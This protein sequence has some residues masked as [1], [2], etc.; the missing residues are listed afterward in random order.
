MRSNHIAYVHKAERAWVNMIKS[1]LNVI[2]AIKLPWRLTS[3]VC[4]Q[5]DKGLPHCDAREQLRCLHGR[6]YKNKT[7]L[8]CRNTIPDLSS[9]PLLGITR[10]TE[11]PAAALMKF[12]SSESPPSGSSGSSGSGGPGTQ[13]IAADSGHT[14]SRMSV[15]RK[16]R[17]GKRTTPKTRCSC[18]R[19][20]GTWANPEDISAG[21]IS[22]F[23][24]VSWSILRYSWAN[25]S[26]S[27]PKREILPRK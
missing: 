23:L 19:C 4:C 21:C 20:F 7:C 13:K 27:V 3:W 17:P 24:S 2:Q 6:T 5:C 16:L 10:V 9:M 8:T 12:G 15:M 22:P 26:S 14:L 18:P 1:A 25:G 11:P